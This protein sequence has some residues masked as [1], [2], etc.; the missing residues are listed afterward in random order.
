MASDPS[1]WEVEG[2][3]SGVQGHL[4]IHRECVVSLGYMMPMC[5]CTHAHTKFNGVRREGR[6]GWPQDSSHS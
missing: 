2:G 3:E 6:A 1:T 4:G 5:A